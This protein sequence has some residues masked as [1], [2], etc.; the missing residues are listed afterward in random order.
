LAAFWRLRRAFH[1]CF[2]LDFTRMCL[3]L[4]LAISFTSR[5]RAEKRH[6]YSTLATPRHVF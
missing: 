1:A 5:V 4:D 6:T 3:L 2:L